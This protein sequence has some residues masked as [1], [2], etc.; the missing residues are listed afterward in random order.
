MLVKPTND[1][2]G[3]QNRSVL[4]CIV[5]EAGR[6]LSLDCSVESPG[7]LRTGDSIE[8]VA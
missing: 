1:L 3:Y 8:L 6:K 4:Q 2:V 7:S 5:K